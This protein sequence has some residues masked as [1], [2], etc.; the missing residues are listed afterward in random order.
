MYSYC[1]LAFYC[2]FFYLSSAFLTL[3]LKIWISSLY[4]RMIFYILY[5]ETSLSKKITIVFELF[6]VLDRLF[7]KFIQLDLKFLQMLSF[8]LVYCLHSCHFISNEASLMF[9]L[10][11]VDFFFIIFQHSVNIIK[12]FFQYISRCFIRNQFVLFFCCSFTIFMLF[13]HF[14]DLN[15]FILEFSVSFLKFLNVFGSNQ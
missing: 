5:L 6:G 13:Q 2:F 8:L 4:L 11:C 9:S 1:F 10:Q 15:N 7:R 3:S 12:L 14:I